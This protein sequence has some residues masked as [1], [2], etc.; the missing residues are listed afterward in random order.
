MRITPTC[1]ALAS[2]LLAPCALATSPAPATPEV[3]WLTTDFPPLYILSG[4]ERGRGLADVAQNLVIQRLDG[5]RHTEEEVPANYPR[6]EQEMKNWAN[7]CFAGFLKTP[8]RER[9]F[10]FSD[11]YRLMLPIHLFTLVDHAPLPTHG[12]R[13]DL[14]ALLAGGQLRLGVLGGRRYGTAIDELLAEHPDDKAV[15]RRYAQ[16]QLEGLLGMMA[17]QGRGIDAV[18]AYPNEVLH[19][20]AASGKPPLDVRRYAIEGTPE[21]QEGYIACSRSALGRQVIAA[22]NGVIP[23]VRQAVAEVYDAE[24]PEADRPRYRALLQRLFGI[25]P[26]QR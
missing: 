17:S 16:D 9:A 15:Y 12:G 23:Q 10:I 18:L 1:L 6:I 7:V 25:T 4:P 24:L 14:R 2:A 20:T 5:F 22:V 3:R 13:V 26:G 19:R 11:A 21:Y 8:E